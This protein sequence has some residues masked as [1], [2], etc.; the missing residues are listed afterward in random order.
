M[1]EAV[2][3]WKG[4]W[5]SDHPGDRPICTRPFP[6][7][8]ISKTSVPSLPRISEG[9]GTACPV[10]LGVPPGAVADAGGPQAPCPP[11]P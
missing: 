6:N 10:N 4:D 8:P 2:G 1:E 11:V 5:K 9:P 7:S 3:F